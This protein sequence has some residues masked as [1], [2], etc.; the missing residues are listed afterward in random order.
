MITGGT[1]VGAGGGT[2]GGGTTGVMTGGGLAPG[3]ASEDST[4]HMQSPQ[5]DGYSVFKP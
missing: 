1:G 2:T 4:Q 3:A 5:K